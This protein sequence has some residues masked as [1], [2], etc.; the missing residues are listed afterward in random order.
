LPEKSTILDCIEGGCLLNLSARRGRNQKG[1]CFV[2][3]DVSPGVFK[4][5]YHGTDVYIDVRSSEKIPPDT[6]IIDSRVSDIL[7]VEETCDISL[8]PISS[9]ISNCNEIRL[10]VVS[11]RGLDNQQVAQAMSK[12]IDDFQEFLDGLILCVDQQI[13]ISKLGI[14][15]HILSIG[16]VDLATNAARISWKQLLKI[17]LVS[18]E[19]NS[20]NLC[21]IAETAA[22]TQIVDVN[23]GD[24]QI[25]RH[26]AILSAL[27]N[28]EEQFT[29]Y[30]P[31]VLFS[32]IAFSDEVS[33][34]IMFDHHTGEELEVSSLHS[35]SIIGAFREWIDSI[36]STNLNLPSN[37]GEA[38]KYGL[39]R[40]QSLSD[41]NNQQTIVLFFSSGIYSA[42]QNPVKIA[43]T[44]GTQ[45]DVVVYALSMGANSVIDIMEAI[46]KE[47][48]GAFI[49]IDDIEKLDEIV[50][51]IDR[52]VLKER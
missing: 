35:S 15:L 40:A 45:E 38:L 33:S 46:A 19:S 29:D 32:G 11:T 18:M 48:N 27:E 23:S 22:A 20:Y 13:P 6:I 25:S 7:G 42:G 2:S 21:I 52:L 50:D 30:G 41:S 43:R 37:P 1:L 39:T 24:Q 44:Q 5:E 4:I 8:E 12:R 26:E 31:D 34:F 36:A 51:T 49:H 17:N 16:P 10:G 14:N 28:I 3:K 9:E 47:G